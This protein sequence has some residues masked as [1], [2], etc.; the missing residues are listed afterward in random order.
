MLFSWFVAGCM[1]VFSKSSRVVFDD[2]QSPFYCHRFVFLFA[3]WAIVLESVW[4]L[5][6]IITLVCSFFIASILRLT[7]LG[8]NQGL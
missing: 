4:I 8:S 6:G 3:Y 5:V 7:G 1:T 2:D